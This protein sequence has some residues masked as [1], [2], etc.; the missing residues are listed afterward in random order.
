MSDQARDGAIQRVVRAFLTGQLAP[1]LL[2]VA[3]AAGVVA[4]LATPREEEPQ[5][6]VPTADVLVAFPGAS[7]EEVEK[8]VATPLE[9]LLWQIDGVE[10]VYS[11][12]RRD[13]ALVT[14]RSVVGEDRERALV[15]L[16]SKIDSHRDEVPP[17]VTGW[18]VRPVEIDDVPI[19]TL[20]LWSATADES[21]LRRV[22]E[23]LAAR[24]ATVPDLSRTEIIGGLRR[25]LRV[26]LEPEALVA[27]A[28][29]PLEVTRALRAADASLLAGSFARADRSTLVMAGPFVGDRLEVERLVVGAHGGR[30]VYLRD[31]AH[32]IDGA[33]ERQS[34]VRLAFGPG[35]R[36]PG[37]P[38]G[39][40]VPA[41]TIALAKKKGTN[42]VHVAEAVIAQAER[43]RDSM[44]PRAM[45]LEVTRNHG[46]SANQKVNELLVHLSLA[47]VTVVGLV[48][49]ALGWREGVI[50]AAAVPITFALT[51]LVN[52][53]FGYSINRVTLFALVLVL[54]LVCDDPIVDV[55]NIHRHFAKRKL[56]PLDA[57]LAAVNEVRPPVIVA[58]LAVILSFLPL[59][60]IT[61][62]MGPYMRPM[63]INVPVAMAMSLLVA[64]SITPWMSYHLLRSRYGSGESHEQ[65]APGIVHRAYA[66]VVRALLEHRAWR[67]LLFATIAAL[68]AVSGVLIVQG[69]VPLKMLPYDNKSELQ[70]VLDLPEGTTLEATSAAAAD[71]ERLLA[72]VPEVESFASYVG[73]ASPIDFNG[74]VRR[75]Y[76]RRGGNLAD[77]RVNLVDKHDR[78]Q[79]SHEILLRLR[80]DLAAVAERHGARLKLVEVPPGPPVLATL[81]A[82]VRGAADQRYQELI[83]GAREL[84][85]RLAAAAGVVDVDV[86]AEDPH[87]RI[88]FVLDKEKAALHGAST[89]DVTR[90]L[91]L[92]LS[93]EIAATVHE[94]D[95]RQPLLLRTIVSRAQRSG[96][97]ELARLQVK[98]GDGSLVPLGELGTFVPRAEE[99]PIFHK[100]LERVSFVLAEVAGRSPADAVFALQR[101]LEREPLARGL[102]VEW[103]GEGEWQ[104]TLD[105]FRD[106]GL[107]FLAALVA[108][109]VL[110][111]VE[112]RSFLMPLVIMLAIPLGAVGIVPGFYLL[113]LVA[114]GSV[115]GYANPIWFTATGMI[116]MI[117]LA[118]IVVRNSIILIDFIQSKVGHGLGLEAAIL[119]SGA[120]R[121]RPIVLTAGAAMLGAWPITLD[122]IF[123]GLAWSLIFGLIAST[124]FT[125]VVVPV[126]YHAT[127][128]A[129]RR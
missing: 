26:E 99:Q 48:A 59:L 83:D 24:L 32:V 57:V 88:D 15:R 123:S 18:V 113:N 41:V 6:V 119:E 112:T 93:G 111:V 1:M 45:R 61:G 76:L 101:R 54:G 94:L 44:L 27:H 23:E 92:A 128:R 126:V 60:F 71:C 73:T 106:L 120:A 66:A 104:I 37:V 118:G 117:A 51:L 96:V 43:L 87:A 11:V 84:E 29:S 5:I 46:R 17:G 20:T 35:A 82:E 98:G 52:W 90:T 49:I 47:I 16:Q 109:Y 14:V 81:V 19:V 9:R 77:L 79:Q 56:P 50:V 42:A 38:V 69:G 70:V 122:P 3:V 12:A 108:I 125:L 97:P 72:T 2:L 116:G 100:D 74:L 4:V 64:F 78:V 86:M 33:E 65:G 129:A 40:S 63:A 95:E 67:W 127:R 7:A 68:F 31:I 124:G 114:G 103:A 121:L 21:S 91:A 36:D 25:E 105:V 55:E 107:A 22:A 28:L 62:M 85:R 8:L 30:P 110:L 13:G 102:L 39:T 75:Y 10:H 53:L 80:R 34:Y 89:Q 115:G 58:T